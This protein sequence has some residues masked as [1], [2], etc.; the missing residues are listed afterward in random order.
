MIN[1]SFKYD[2][3]TNEYVTK[4]NNQIIKISPDTLNFIYKNNYDKE[5]SKLLFS[6][7]PDEIYSLYVRLE[8]I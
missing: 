3:S 2:H 7:I 1:E 6:I 4:Y 5:A 8:E